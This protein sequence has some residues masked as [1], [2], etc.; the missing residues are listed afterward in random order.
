[1]KIALAQINTTVSDIRGNVARIRAF[2][3]RAAALGADLTVFPEQSLGGY[4][5]LDLWEERGFIEAN[6]RA[7]RRLAKETEASEMGLLVGLSAGN[8]RKTGK[9]VRNAAALLHKGKI[10]VRSKTLLPT[11]DVFDEARYFEPALSNPPLKFKGVQLGVT[12]CEDAWSRGPGGKRLYRRDPVQAQAKAGAEVL[13]NISASPFERGKAHA[14]LRLLSEH[15]RTARRPLLYC[16][17]IGGNDEIIF[18]GRSLA[19]DSRG[20]LVAAAKAFAEDLLLVDLANVP[21]PL[22]AP[23]PESDISEAGEALCL[24]IRD[25]AGK[26]GFER[27]LV[28]LSGGIDSAVVCAL[29]ARA[30][31]PDKVLGVSMPSMYS[32]KGSLADARALA[33]NLGIRHLTLPISGIYRRYM[34]VL[35]EAFAGKPENLAEQNLQARIR[36]TLLMA[37][38]NKHACMLLSTGNKSELSV[39]Y[40]TLYGDMSGGLAVL[41]DVPKRTVYE[42]AQWLNRKAGV[43]PRSSIE[44]APSAELR[45]NQKDQDDLPA[46]ETLDRILEAYI[47]AR[48]GPEELARTGL[49]P[50][51]VEDMLNRIDKSEYKRRQAPPSLKISSKAFGVGR[52]MPLARGSYRA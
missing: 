47:E 33:Q 40:C 31:G 32:S 5:A 48:L 15:A 25:Y 20:R 6:E 22:A 9:P 44:K 7:L 30:L 52:R 38:S 13:V 27:V 34:G 24:G 4:P 49:D 16:N 29:A 12:I 11:Y 18:D 19:L 35:R 3:A 51:L 50:L 23:S 42:L 21:K 26:C 10:S 46:Y 17:L 14:R 8:P 28:G 1:M 41:A 36:G 37:L 43:I 39:G 45:P 2:A